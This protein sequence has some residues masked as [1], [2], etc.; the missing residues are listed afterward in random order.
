MRVF[1]DI[2]FDADVSLERSRGAFFCAFIE[3]HPQRLFADLPA[4]LAAYLFESFLA[5]T[6]DTLA[7]ANYLVRMRIR[8]GLR[9]Q[10]S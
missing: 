7:Q 6:N 2:I 8:R 1:W 4:L 9:W 10:R 5:W 3:E